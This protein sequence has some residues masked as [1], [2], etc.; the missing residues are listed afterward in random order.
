M[1]I[2]YVVSGDALVDLLRLLADLVSN[3]RR[4]LDLCLHDGALRKGFIFGALS[5]SQCRS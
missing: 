3:I 4:W 5:F 1:S 2:L